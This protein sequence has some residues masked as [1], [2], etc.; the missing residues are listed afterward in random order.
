[1]GSDGGMEEV[2]SGEGRREVAEEE[3][4]EAPRLVEEMKEPWLD[5]LRRRR[6]GGGKR[7]IFDDG[8]RAS[9]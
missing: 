3:A 4:W 5:D 2:V 1:M 8:G 7:D 6:E 9:D